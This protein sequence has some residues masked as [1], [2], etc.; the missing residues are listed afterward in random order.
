MGV[1]SVV[2]TN[3]QERVNSAGLGCPSPHTFQKNGLGGG[4]VAQ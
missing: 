2:C 1:N 3:V 4:W